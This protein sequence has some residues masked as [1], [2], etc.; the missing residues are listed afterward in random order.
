MSQIRVEQ[1]GRPEFG[2]QWRSRE[3]NQFPALP[4][5]INRIHQAVWRVVSAMLM[6]GFHMIFVGGRM[7]RLRGP[8]LLPEERYEFESAEAR[9]AFRGT[10]W[11]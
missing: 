4:A 11:F 3:R 5:E 8:G 9:E 7:V 1:G 6:G 10:K 2:R